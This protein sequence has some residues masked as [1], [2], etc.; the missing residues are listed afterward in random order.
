MPIAS[1]CVSRRNKDLTR[2][3]P[4]V[5]AAVARVRATTAI[6]DGEIVAVDE[7]ACRGPWL[8]FGWAGAFAA[9]PF[10]VWLYLALEELPLAAEESR[11]PA[12]D[13]SRDEEAAPPTR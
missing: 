2:D 4:S 12:R 13:N 9:M 5:A 10:A 8:P 6:L 7:M 11:D 3:F 1:G